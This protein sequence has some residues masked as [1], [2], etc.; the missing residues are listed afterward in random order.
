MAQK[1]YVVREGFN[2]RVRTERG[3]E[4]V[5]SEGDI[6][7]LDPDTDSIGHQLELADEK[8][9]AAAL[10]EENQAARAASMARAQSSGIDQD[11]L[12]AAIAEGVARALQAMQPGAAAGAGTA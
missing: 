7:V 11:A 3:E 9:R 12:A 1:R 5:Y 4:K 10:K 2:Y 6:V 8:D